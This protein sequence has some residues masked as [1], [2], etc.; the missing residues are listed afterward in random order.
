MT[1]YYTYD[2]LKLI[3]EEWGNNV[4]V[5]LYDANGSPIGM[6]YRTTSYDEGE[7]D[8]YYYEKNLQGDIIAMYSATGAKIVSYDYDPWGRI[9]SMTDGNG[10]DVRNNAS[11]L[12]NI[13]PLRYRGYY[14]DR[15]LSLYYL[16]ARYYDPFTCR[17]ITADSYV[18]TGQGILGHNRYAY[19][20]NNPVMYV[21]RTGESLTGFLLMSVTLGFVWGCVTLCLLD[22][23]SEEDSSANQ[24]SIDDDGTTLTRKEYY[25][26]EVQDV[27]IGGYQ[28]STSARFEV[29]VHKQTT[30]LEN[31]NFSAEFLTADAGINVLGGNLG[32]YLGKI[33]ISQDLELTTGQK[34]TVGIEMNFGAGVE[35]NLA[36]HTRIGATAGLGFTLIL[37]RER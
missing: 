9:V 22:G 1:H 20:G 21:D 35:F 37:E 23:L 26:F 2:G 17:F 8:T 5:F 16:A 18:S 13:N 31:L 7:W 29:G 34:I 30:K 4:L 14:Y 11:H 24:T 36:S 33:G 28:H 6:Q 10:N 25:D 15:D 27:N 32:V 19:C 3:R 12:G